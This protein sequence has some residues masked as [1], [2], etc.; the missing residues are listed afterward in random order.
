METTYFITIF[1]SGKEK[2]KVRSEC[3]LILP[4]S[5][6]FYKINEESPTKVVLGDPNI[7]GE[8]GSIT[9]FKN[10]SEMEGNACL[11]CDC[12]NSNHIDEA[13]HQAGKAN[14]SYFISSSDTL[15]FKGNKIPAIIVDKN[16][17]NILK[18]YCENKDTVTIKLSQVEEISSDDDS[19]SSGNS[20]TVPYYD[21]MNHSDPC[22]RHIFMRVSYRDKG[23][24]K[25]AYN[26]FEKDLKVRILL[27]DGQDVDIPSSCVVVQPKYNYEKKFPVSFKDD[28]YVKGKGCVCDY[29]KTKF[30]NKVSDLCDRT[31]K[32]L[33][34]ISKPT[35]IKVPTVILNDIADIKKLTPIHLLVSFIKN[36]VSHG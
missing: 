33:F 8:T 30:I 24:K 35:K 31:A 15:S 1:V 23:S 5:D 2:S 11:Y 21:S 18:E 34:V 3:K 16:N 29:K 7:R 17:C 14:A 26:P 22:D 36:D 25:H 6:S 13:F 32:V 27:P 19:Y 4:D 20:S 10:G 9:H 12:D 28:R